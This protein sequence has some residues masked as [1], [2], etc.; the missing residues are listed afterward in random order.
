MAQ[1]AWR[2]STRVV[3]IASV[4]K[5]AEPLG[6]VGL[7]DDGAGTHDFPS[8]APGVARGTDLIQPPKGRWQFFCLGKRALAGSRTSAIDSKDNPRSSLSIQQATCLPLFGERAAERIIEKQRAQGLDWCLG[9]SHQKARERRAGWQPLTLK[10]RHEGDGKGLQPLVEGF[11]RAFTADGIA[12]EDGEKVDHLI[13]SEA[14]SP[15]AHALTELRQDAL[16]AQMLN[17]QH[18]FA[19]PRRR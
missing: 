8:L 2:S 3:P 11:Q 15:K 5:R 9:Q 4:A 12:K 19:K 18:D 16:L 17:D 6:T 13:L 10:Q 1:R 14:S 7:T